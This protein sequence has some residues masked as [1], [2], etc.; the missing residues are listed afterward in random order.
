MENHAIT[1]RP[2]ETVKERLKRAAHVKPSEAQLKWMEKEFTAFIHI[3][4]NTYTGRQWG[5]GTEVVTDYAATSLDP[6]QWIAVCAKAGMKMATTTLKHHDGFC[7]WD[8]KTTDFNIMNAPV[9]TDLTKRI[10]DACA[11]EG[12]DFGVYLS[13]WDMHQREL[14]VWGTD[15]YQPYFMAQLKEL[16]ENYGPVGELWFDGACGDT[17]IWAPAPGYKP[18][19][20]Y[21]YIANQHKDAVCRMY[22]PYFFADDEG[23]EKL[24]KGEGE[25]QWWGRGV[26]W[27]GNEQGYT[28]EGEWSVQ[29]VRDQTIAQNA[30]FPDLGEEYYYENAVGAIWYPVEVNT[31]ITN[32]WFW[33]PETTKVKSLKELID[34]FYHSIGNN[35]VLLLNL[36]PDRD[37]KV[38]QDQV[39]RLME[40]REFMDRF[41][42]KDLADGAKAEASEEAAGHEAARMLDGDK[43]TY[44]TVDR[45]W[46]MDVDKAE[47]LIDLGEARTFD[48]LMLAEFLRE[49]QRIV[50]WHAEALVDGQWKLLTERKTVGYR[51]I[52]HFPEVTTDKVRITID[53]AWDQPTLSR[54]ALYATDEKYKSL[55]IQDEMIVGPEPCETVPETTGLHYDMYQGGVQ[56]AQLVSMFNTHVV[57]AGDGLR[58]FTVEQAGQ[59]TD[60]GMRFTG[61]VHVVE[62]GMYTFNMTSADASQIYLNH[63]LCVNNDEPHDRRKVTQKVSL[64]KGYYAIDVRYTCFRHD[65]LLKVELPEGVELV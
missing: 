53:R 6:E 59:P 11:K 32:Q 57:K 36:S 47:I 18:A 16:L 22:D 41:F 25:L 34:L 42:A 30:T 43:M 29:P 51:C 62:D 63:E 1:F 9:A 23:W 7:Q 58:D 65:A 31:T 50:K 26:R 52:I 20:W 5:N 3:S 13:P 33:D 15:A 48:N 54:I 19:E 10:S 8:T 45:E 35:G 12:I 28:R 56:S 27:V 46:D 17:K 40:F 55:K 24:K 60:F 4:P 37:G 49:G 21:E 39:E 64:K 2:D 61:F 14:G 38:P 44:W